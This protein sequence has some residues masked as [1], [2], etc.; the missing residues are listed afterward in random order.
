MNALDLA[1]MRSS[2]GQPVARDGQLPVCVIG[3]PPT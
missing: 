2:D 1:T 3:F